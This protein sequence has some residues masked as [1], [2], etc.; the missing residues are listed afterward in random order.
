MPPG[1]CNDGLIAKANYRIIV[2][3]GVTIYPL[4]DFPVYQ[5]HYKGENAGI[6]ASSGSFQIG[7][8]QKDIWQW[9]IDQL[10]EGKMT[11]LPD[12]LYEEEWGPW[13]QKALDEGC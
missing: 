12:E 4:L 6:S 8:K 3:E 5:I 11:L 10:G 2:F 7:E 9:L 1:A 13:R